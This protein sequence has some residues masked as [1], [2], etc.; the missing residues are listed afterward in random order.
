VKAD[1]LD[2]IDVGDAAWDRVLEPARC[3]FYHQRPY[4]ALAQW[5]GEGDAVLAVY[6]SEDRYLAWPYLRRP[7]PGSAH[8]DATSVYGYAGPI[9]V[10]EETMAPEEAHR[11]RRAAWEELTRA[12]AEQGIV[13]VFT[14]FNP[15]VD[16]ARLSDGWQ[17]DPAGPEPAVRTLGRTVS[18]DLTMS[19][20]ERIATYE[21]ETRRR[22]RRD[23]RA[24]LETF[25]DAGFD[26][27]GDM[28][29]LYTQTMARNRVEARYYFTPAYFERFVD[30]M[31]GR[32]HLMVASMEGEV[33][34]G[35]IFVVTGDVAQA[36]LAA[37]SDL[38]LG[39]SPL[40]S[41]FDATAD[42]AQGLGARLLHLGSGRGGV[43]DSLFQFKRRLSQCEHH[44]AVGRWVVDGARYREF[45]RMPGDG[46][47][48]PTAFF[49]AYRAPG[50]GESGVV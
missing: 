48:D 40:K 30:E 41:V 42:A 20:E 10:G 47:S 24:G 11:F 2:L 21:P 33:I 27:L 28:V 36:H 26:R 8:F 1:R 14:S 43:E 44:Y 37:V 5:H 25:V 6:G 38:H 13:S 39:V 50:H 19:R 45:A 16:N 15:L 46:V 7:I 35:L 9:L 49:P 32:A 3:D 34:A 31:S 23:L 29:E 18:M 12:W 17:G 22:I 4:H